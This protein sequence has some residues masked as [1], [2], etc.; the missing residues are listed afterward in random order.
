M[1]FFEALQAYYAPAVA[2]VFFAVLLAADPLLTRR[3]KQLFL[4]ELGVVGLMILSTWTDRCISAVT[5][6][7]WWRL[8]FFTSALQFAA[9]PL[10]PLILLKIYK[11]NQIARLEWLQALPAVINALL[12]MSSFWTGLVLRV[13]PGNVYSRGPLFLLPFLASA[14]YMIFI[15][16][17]ASQGET[18]GRRMETIF[19][20][21]AGAA[22]T[23]ACV[24]EIVF[25]IRY[26]IWGTTAVM[27]LMYFL[28]VNVL[29]VLYDMQTGVYSRL[30]YTKRMESIADGRLATLA[31]IDLNE[32]KA[33]NDRYGHKAGDQAI[34]QVSR[35]LLSIP[36]RGAKLYRYGGDEFV[37]VMD[38]WHGQ[39]LEAELKQIAANCGAVE[40]TA[41]SFAYG[42]VEHRG[43]E[44]HW[45]TEEM[46]RRM[47]RNKAEMKAL[48]RARSRYSSWRS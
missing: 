22:I 20:F 16:R 45:T 44:L 14:L 24:C 41:L 35:A 33:I 38:G 32:L 11:R 37:I 8:R 39:E 15:F 18:P 4:A 28:L 40:G 43:G 1:L 19:L 5:E 13:G 25:V 36:V 21:S 6:G 30:A 31:M 29:K 17:S 3:E 10:S 12:A 47:Y 9:A 27:L 2:L 7:N 46:D 48:R 42:V 34:V 26:M 23:G